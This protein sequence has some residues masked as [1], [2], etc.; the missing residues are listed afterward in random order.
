MQI[1]NISIGTYKHYKT[2]KLYK[3]IGI[4]RHSE[5]HQEM[6]IYKALYKSDKFDYN[7]LWVRPKEMFFESV[8]YE[9]ISIPRFKYI[10]NNK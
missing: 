1:D 3:V 7:Q 6:V 2:N 5:T 8:I 4:A 10:D 9:G